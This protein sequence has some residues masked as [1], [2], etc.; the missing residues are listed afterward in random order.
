MRPLYICRG[1]LEP[2]LCKPFAE[3]SVSLMFAFLFELGWKGS[4]ADLRSLVDCL[5][6]QDVRQKGD[7]VG[8]D[9]D[10][11]ENMNYVWCQEVADLACMCT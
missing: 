1:E 2:L 10:D 8:L 7:F 3:G 11:L 6:A 4:D 5:A 9:L